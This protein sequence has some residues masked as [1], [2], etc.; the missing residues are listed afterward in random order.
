MKTKL[1]ILFGGK[2]SEYDVSLI[3]SYGVLSNVD[4]EKY[5][6]TCIGITREGKWLLF[7][8]DIEEI[9][10]DTWCSHMENMNTVVVNP[11]PGSDN[12]VIISPKGE[13]VKTVSVDAIFP[14]M[15][16]PFCEDGTL[17]GMLSLCGIPYVG[18]KSTSSGICMDK[19]F[20]K[21][22][23]NSVGI[24]QAKA[25]IVLESRWNKK[26][27]SIKA[28]IAKL[29]YPVF[30]KPSRAG[31]SVG[32]SKVKNES[33]LDAAL[34]FAFI[35]DAKVL[36]EEYIKGREIEVAVMEE[37]GVI[38]ASEV[39]EIDPGCDF[40]D[41][42]TKYVSDTASYYIPARITEEQRET[43]RNRAVKI[44]ETLDCR[45]LSRV[46]FFVTDD[47]E[48][49]FNEINTLPGFTPISMYPKLFMH[50]GMTYADVIDRLV[51]SA[52]KDKLCF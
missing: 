9:K 51:Q 6:V 16:G 20:T 29:G 34:K 35:Q 22:I 47:G 32:V 4:R 28:E 26:S 13:T 17:Q 12:F 40:Y 10:N 38:T 14:V 52:L 48:I 43:I 23:I 15:H 39:G 41:Y 19:A 8:G 1:C 21:Q 3:S 45:T 25:V 5:D 36:V 46:D 50:T 30:V 24:R 37:D 18:P 44:F 11:E 49:V 2:S 7:E 31:S 27:D 42:E 33:E